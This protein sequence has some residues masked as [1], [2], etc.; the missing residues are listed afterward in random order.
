M[1]QQDMAGKTFPRLNVRDPFDEGASVDGLLTLDQAGCRGSLSRPAQETPATGTRGVLPAL[2]P[3]H[4]AL[5]RLREG[6]QELRGGL[7]HA[8]AGQ[9]QLGGNDTLRR[10]LAR[11][12]F[13]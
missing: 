6:V 5:N 9:P 2:V 10:L 7:F 12:A 3:C 11:W 1:R 4:R 13:L 8:C